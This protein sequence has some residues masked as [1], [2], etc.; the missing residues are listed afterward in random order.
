MPSRPLIVRLR[1]WVGDV[2][3]GLPML[4]RLQAQGYDLMLVGK[5]WAADLF[6]GQGWPVE[7]LADG[8][9]ARVHQ[10]RALRARALQRDPGFAR[11]PI[12]ALCLP[13]SFSSAL[14]MRLAGL[15]SIGYAHEGRGW[16]LAQRLPRP[17]AAH[18][19]AVY[20]KLGS[21]LIGADAPLP[22]RVQLSLTPAHRDA[23]A[24]L[25]RLHS[26]A[27]GYVVLCPFA[28]GTFDKIDKC[29]PGFPAFAATRLPPLGRGVVI[30]PGPGEEEVIAAR[31]Y[32]GCLVVRGVGLGTYAALLAD[33]ALVVANDTGPGHLAAAVG[34]PLVSVLGP[35]DPG[36]WGARGP[37]VTIVRGADGW[38]DDDAVFTAVREA[39]DSR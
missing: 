11:Q 37:T 17:I 12:H 4:Q 36:R 16:L 19:M 38:P 32:P 13:Y 35:T 26:I 18:E 30:C 10:L 22:D 3:L 29:W 7:P 33:A 24:E 6:A 25:R 23:A 27:D 9:A 2:A 34:A 20:W 31:D 1:N 14:E 15:R 28:G 21:A 5:R 39:L 8:L